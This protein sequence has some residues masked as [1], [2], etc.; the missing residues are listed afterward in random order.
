MHFVQSTKNFVPCARNVEKKG[1][2]ICRWKRGGLWALLNWGP[3]RSLALVLSL[4]AGCKRGPPFLNSKL[5]LTH[6]SA[7]RL[8][9]AKEPA[10]QPPHLFFLPFFHLFLHSLVHSFIQRVPGKC[11]Q[12]SPPFC[13]PFQASGVIS[14]EHLCLKPNSPHTGKAARVGKGEKDW[15]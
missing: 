5:C 1:E 7:L 11:L 15:L 13:V 2:D 14:V 8:I 10:G 12:C 4:G 3:A 6:P 9:G